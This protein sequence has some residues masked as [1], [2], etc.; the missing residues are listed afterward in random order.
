MRLAISD[1]KNIK[2][3]ASALSQ[4]LVLSTGA[5][6]CSAVQAATQHIVEA[7]DT[8]SAIALYY[9][10]SQTAL[11]DTNGLVAT[12]LKTGQ[13]LKVPNRDVNH[14]MYRVEAGDSLNSLSKRYNVDVETLASV[15]K[16][17][18]DAGLLINSTLIIPVSDKAA[19]KNT[20]AG[21][22]KVVTTATPAAKSMASV[23]GSVTKYRIKYGDSLSQ[24]SQLY[25]V[26]I[27]QLAQENNMSINDPLYFG[28]YLTIPTTSTAPKVAVTSEP[29]ANQYTIQ[30]GDTLMG[31]AGKFNV[32]FMD[33]AELN[34]MDY[35]DNLITG[36]VLKIPSKV[37]NESY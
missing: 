12:N 21:A 10:V 32:G 6:L 17:S 4:V 22:K 5:L 31:I 26:S 16:L 2:H 1:I 35:N 28:R 13:I 8:I 37:S 19:T 27:N 20:T 24:V 29:V 18:A 15:N 25:N 9:N 34:G 36:K 11:I 14:N 30:A 33:I 3:H 23:D 7:G